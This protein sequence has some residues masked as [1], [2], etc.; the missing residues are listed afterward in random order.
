MYPITSKRKNLLFLTKSIC[1]KEKNLTFYLLLYLN[2]RNTNIMPLC[3]RIHLPYKRS[4]YSHRMSLISR[5]K[6]QHIKYDHWTYNRLIWD[7]STR[8]SCKHLLKSQRH[9]RYHDRKYHLI[10]HF[11]YSTY[12]M[13]ICYFSSF[14]DQK[15]AP[16][17]RS[18]F[19]T[20][21]NTNLCLHDQ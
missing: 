16:A 15:K 11:Q 7:F 6:S 14:T 18:A 20:L 5:K 1:Y 8:A 4:R 21:C 19:H 13:S 10:K 17:K 9:H 12:P 3:T 2:V